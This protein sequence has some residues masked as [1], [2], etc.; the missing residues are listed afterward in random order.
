M[1]K[2]LTAKSRASALP[3]YRMLRRK[4]DGAYACAT[5]KGA[6]TYNLSGGFH[7]QLIRASR[8][9]QGQSAGDGDAIDAI[10]K[11]TGIN[12]ELNDVR[13]C[14]YNGIIISRNPRIPSVG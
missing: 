10:R 13:R 3:R 8:A 6:S 9:G 2:P 4:G 5:V 7:F 11:A 12:I 14:D 1:N